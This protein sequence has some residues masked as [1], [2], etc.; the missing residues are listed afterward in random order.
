MM[1][2]VL[3]SNV[4]DYEEDYGEGSSEYYSGSYYYEYF[5]L[6]MTFEDEW[7][8]EHELQLKGDWTNW[9]AEGDDRFS[10][11]TD[12]KVQ[13]YRDMFQVTEEELLLNN[14]THFQSDD[15]G[16]GTLAVDII[17]REIFGMLLTY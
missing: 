10:C 13:E 15:W 8:E 12:A 16:F 3:S 14:G 9:N 6:G 4:T 17:L 5:D 11:F 1:P 2:M 7:G